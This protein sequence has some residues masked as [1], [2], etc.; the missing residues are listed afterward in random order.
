[1]RVLVIG[2]GAIGGILGAYLSRGGVDVTMVD[3][4]PQHVQV[5]QKQ[6]LT[7]LTPESRTVFPVQADT[8]EHYLK[9]LEAQKEMLPSCILLAVKAQYTR[10][11]VEPFLPF[12]REDCFIISA[13]NGLCE[14][15]LAKL[16]GR[17]RVVAGFVNIFSDYLEPG[18]INY[19]GKGALAIGELD[20]HRSQRM[21]DLEKQLIGL[22]RL[23]ISDNLLGYLWGK[24]G[25]AAILGVTTLSNA[26]MADTIENPDYRQLLLHLAA[27]TYRTAQAEGIQLLP[28]DDFDPVLVLAADA[29]EA[30][31][32]KLNQ[33]FEVH[34]AR[35]RTYTKIHSGIWRDIAVRGRKTEI[36][37][38]LDPAMEMG[39][40]YGESFALTRRMLGMIHELEDGKRT[41]DENN[42]RLLAKAV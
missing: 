37:A 6:G 42:I 10:T 14:Y 33:M 8:V 35:L 18:V 29:G 12:L 23:E 26:S 16:V 40:K 34:I 11:A 21:N 2:A 9:S 27:E 4:D 5:M 17:K 24:I 7:I 31:E 28:F 41:F 3:T 22:D 36:E 38:L 39:E 15:E 32:Q 30:D 13:Q 1:M 25:Y 19:G 20:G